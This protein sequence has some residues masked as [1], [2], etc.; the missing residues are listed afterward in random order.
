MI[1]NQQDKLYT[2]ALILKDLSGV[3]HHHISS[4]FARGGGLNIYE[5]TSV[6]RAC[7]ILYSRNDYSFF[8]MTICLY[9]P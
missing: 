1:V 3:V 8:T 9:K 4:F 7:L 2:P 6:F 5:L